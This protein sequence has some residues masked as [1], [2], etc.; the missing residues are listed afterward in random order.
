MRKQIAAGNWKMNLSADEAKALASEVTQFYQ[1]EYNG[2]AEVIFGVPFP[3]LA[4]ISEITQS[5]DGVYLSS[6]N[7]CTE[8]K[9]AYT[10]ETSASMLVSVG[11]SHAIIGH[12]ERRQY[13][14]ETNDILAK[15][16]DQ[17]LAHGLVPIYCIGETL[18]QREAGETLTVNATQLSEG[19]FHLDAASFGKLIVAYEPVWAIGTGKTASPEQAQEVHAAIRQQIADKYGDEVAQSTRILYGGSMKPSNVESL[20]AQP[21]IDGGLV[22][23]ASLKSGDFSEIIKAM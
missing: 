7:V 4:L 1:N 21:D 5:A 23:G 16:I 6:Q 20:I 12:S 10:G 17:A 13:Y 3:Y 8:A 11:V 2:T 19:A 14:G 9:G 18:E 15:K 22:G